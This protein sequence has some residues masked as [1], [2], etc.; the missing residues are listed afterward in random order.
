[1]IGSKEFVNKMIRSQIFK[2]GLVFLAYGTT[3]F[4]SWYFGE[5]LSHYWKQHQ[6]IVVMFLY[7]LTPLLAAVL[8]IAVEKLYRQPEI[9]KPVESETE[10]AVIVRSFDSKKLDL[11]SSFRR[12]K[13]ELESAGVHED[14]IRAIDVE[15][16]R[17]KNEYL[18]DKEAA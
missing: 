3:V 9:F 17:L 13:L 2:W 8:W 1:M 12:L 18:S 7:I 6:N 5:S 16:E 15:L 14:T 4:L 11:I 10:V